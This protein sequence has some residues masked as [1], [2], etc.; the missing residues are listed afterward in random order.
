MRSD[1]ACAHGASVGF[2][3]HANR[4]AWRISSIGFRDVTTIT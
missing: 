4:C 1:Q 2:A 3:G